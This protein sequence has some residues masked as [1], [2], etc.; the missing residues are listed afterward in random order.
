MVN[1]NIE[2]YLRWL[3]EQGGYETRRE[4]DPWN[5]WSETQKKG[6][7]VVLAVIVLLALSRSSK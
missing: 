4:G 1:P 5:I 6:T 7:W 3:R 2:A